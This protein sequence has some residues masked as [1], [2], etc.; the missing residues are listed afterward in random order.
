MGEK[1]KE[2]A[3]VF[4]NPQTSLLVQHVIHWSPPPLGFVKLNVVAAI[5]QNSSALA[6]VAR[7]EQ[8]AVLKA[9]SKF[10]PKRT[11]IAAEAKAILWALHLARGENWRMIIVESDAKICINSILDHIGCPQWAI[12]SLVSDI[13]LLEKSFV[14]CLFFLGK[15]KWKRCYSRSSKV[16]SSVFFFLFFLFG[17]SP[18]LCDF[19]LFEMSRLCLFLVIDEIY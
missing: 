16:H 7:N 18:S 9:W 4:S 2:C 1:S 3:K 13:W 11:P 10:M 12:S 15:K 14:S 8:G 17:Q 6:V 5:A 19:C